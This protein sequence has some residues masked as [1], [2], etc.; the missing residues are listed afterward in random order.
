VILLS[1]S[2]EIKTKHNEEGNMIIL[3]EF[4]SLA[5]SCANITVVE[6]CVSSALPEFNML[7][8]LS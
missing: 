6:N 3:L 4:P 7:V 2:T 5:T 8:I 1:K